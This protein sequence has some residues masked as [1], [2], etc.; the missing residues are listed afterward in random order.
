MNATR[1]LTLSVRSDAIEAGRQY[2]DRTGRSLSS[3]VGGFL[4]GL[5][6]ATIPG[7][8]SPAVTALMGV[9]E[10]AHEDDYRRHLEE[11]YL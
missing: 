3:L 11:K 7:S 6:D 4:Q 8:H 9:A 1:K 10:G 5:E 2:S